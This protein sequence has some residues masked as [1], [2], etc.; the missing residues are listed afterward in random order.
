MA[1]ENPIST[2]QMPSPNPR[3]PPVA[4]CNNGIYSYRSTS[5]VAFAVRTNMVVYP[6]RV[7]GQE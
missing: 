6:F 2:S 5:V 4:N 3:F 7:K 1:N